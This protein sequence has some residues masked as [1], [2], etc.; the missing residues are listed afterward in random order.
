MIQEESIRGQQFTEEKNNLHYIIMWYD[1]ILSEELW[2]FACMVVHVSN[3]HNVH[4]YIYL[5]I[6]SNFYNYYRSESLCII[7]MKYISVV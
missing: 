6:N 1:C 2:L 3:S 5:N 4:I 7:T